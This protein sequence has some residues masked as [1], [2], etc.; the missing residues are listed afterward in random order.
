MHPV[1]YG[2]EPHASPERRLWLAVLIRAFTDAF[3]GIEVPGRHGTIRPEFASAS[4]RKSA[5]R[6]LLAERGPWR[7]HLEFV[8]A[9][10]GEE[11][12]RVRRRAITMERNTRTLSCKLDEQE[13]QAAEAKK[14]ANL[15]AL[16]ER[17][18]A[19]ELKAA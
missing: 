1:T 6:L 4:E 12:E 3:P 13:H 8:C 15:E 5:K 10:A 7:K 11:V 18:A 16:A 2:E 14:R 17:R 9:G 19:R